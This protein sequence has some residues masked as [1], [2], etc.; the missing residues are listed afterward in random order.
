MCDRSTLVGSEFP[1]AVAAQWN[2]RSSRG[3]VTR[4]SEN[5]MLQP[6]V[7]TS[8]PHSHARDFIVRASHGHWVYT[9][10][11]T[12]HRSEFPTSLSEFSYFSA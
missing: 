5:Q 10:R 12:T 9:L 6:D 4:K 11:L 8:T 7:L 2:R 1:R 3:S